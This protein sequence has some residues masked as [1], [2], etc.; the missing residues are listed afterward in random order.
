M[1]RLANSAAQPVLHPLQMMSPWTGLGAPSLCASTAQVICTP[2]VT[3]AKYKSRHPMQPS[4]PRRLP[5]RRNTQQPQSCMQRHKRHLVPAK[6]IHSWMHT[7]TKAKATNQNCTHQCRH[8]CLQHRL[9]LCQGVIF[10][11]QLWPIVSVV[12][13][14]P[15]SMQCIPPSV[16]SR[17]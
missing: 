3:Q 4:D 8:L 5:F 17:R 12:P 11:H 7:L 2:L 10:S 14:P 1:P 9:E 16:Q 15:H 6:T 13:D